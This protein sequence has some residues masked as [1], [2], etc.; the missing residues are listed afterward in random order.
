MFARGR[1]LLNNHELQNLQIRCLIYTYTEYSFLAFCLIHQL[2]KMIITFSFKFVFFDTSNRLI[3]R[4]E[5]RLTYYQNQVCN[6][7]TSLIF[8][9]HYVKEKVV[10]NVT[11]P[12]K[13]IAQLNKQINKL[14]VK[15]LFGSLL[16]TFD[17]KCLIHTLQ[18]I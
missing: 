2:L 7:L 12:P 3:G 15:I 5:L 8:L 4:N 14:L 17:Q 1:F 9:R 18:C 11:P 6:R 16:F 10:S 13:K